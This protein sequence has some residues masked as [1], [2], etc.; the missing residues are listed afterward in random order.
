MTWKNNDLN[1]RLDVANKTNGSL[2]SEISLLEDKCSHM[3]TDIDNRDNIIA[4][5]KS[6]LS[7]VQCAKMQL[8]KDFAAANKEIVHLTP[9]KQYVQET[10]GQIKSLQDDLKQT[11]VDAQDM[12]DAHLSN[13]KLVH[14]WRSKLQAMHFNEIVQVENQ[15]FFL[16]KEVDRLET[17][18]ADLDRS[19]RRLK[20]EKMSLEQHI[21]AMK[22]AA[23]D[24]DSARSGERLSWEKAVEELK[25]QHKKEM[26][27]MRIVSADEQDILRN[28]IASLELELVN[29][30]ERNERKCEILNAECSNKVE[31]LNATISRV[32]YESAIET[33]QHSKEKDA[34]SNE[35]RDKR[36][37]SVSLL[38]AKADLENQINSLKEKHQSVIDKLRQKHRRDIEETLRVH[39][40]LFRQH[41]EKYS[42]ENS[43]LVEQIKHLEQEHESITNDSQESFSKIRSRAISIG[44]SLQDTKQ[45]YWELKTLIQQHHD[46]NAIWDQCQNEIFAKLK[47]I[48]QKCIVA[49]EQEK[50]SCKE[51][52]SKLNDLCDIKVKEAKKEAED[53]KK[54]LFRSIREYETKHEREIRRLK[55]EHDF[56]VST[57]VNESKANCDDL[58]AKFKSL[59]NDFEAIIAASG[60]KELELSEKDKNVNQLEMKIIDLTRQHDGEIQSLR[61]QHQSE[62]DSMM[63]DMLAKETAMNEQFAEVKL[64]LE[65]ELDKVRRELKEAN[66]QFVQNVSDEV[67]NME[68]IK[69]L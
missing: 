46:T 31:S 55:E 32:K 21:Q 62:R 61:S 29:E 43:Q 65:A 68:Q 3:C 48:Q 51:T 37:Q 53:A 2:E 67:Q 26:F 23:A 42:N 49:V 34:L 8:C 20:Q 16:R 50:S 5:L 27:H 38:R 44:H 1:Q 28:R 39:V 33:Q 63:R 7:E 13:Q 69:S 35:L 56:H 12:R 54:M 45:V 22:H 19:N 57:V 64:E 47:S 11:F 59:Y 30:H 60:E 41:K 9:Y 15:S 24:I 25:I 10:R 40:E 18:Q 4:S 58:S 66:E 6:E 17:I 14:S 52:V 36:E